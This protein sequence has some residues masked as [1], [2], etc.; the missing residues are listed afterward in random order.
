V[1]ITDTSG[2]V[3]YKDDASEMAGNLNVYWGWVSQDRVWVYNSDDGKIWRWELLNSTWTKIQSHTSDGI[4]AYVLPPYAQ[5][6]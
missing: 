1:T 4:P 3:L 5:K 2:K 6:Y